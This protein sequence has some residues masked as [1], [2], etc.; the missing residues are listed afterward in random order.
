[1]SYHYKVKSNKK[2]DVR[3]NHNFWL[4]FWGKI[5]SQL[6]EGIF[7]IALPW[8][9]LNATAS[10]TAMSTYYIIGNITCGLALFLFGKMID[11]WK[12]EKIMYVTDYIRGIYILFLLFMVLVDLPY[13]FL[14]IYL[15]AVIT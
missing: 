15:G 7:N 14:W 6:G 8:Y 12:K 1:M 5:V 2:A 10:A 13:K 9:I 4:L 3:F 11:R